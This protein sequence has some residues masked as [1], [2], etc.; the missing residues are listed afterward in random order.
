LKS[1]CHKLFLT[2]LPKPKEKKECILPAAAAAAAAS[3]LVKTAKAALDG[4][5][6]WP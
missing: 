6:P 4:K 1:V 3:L 2:S 5:T